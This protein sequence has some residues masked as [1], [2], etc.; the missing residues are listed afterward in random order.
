MLDSNTWTKNE[1]R[2]WVAIHFLL[3]QT[4]L[5]R[6]IMM[7]WEFKDKPLKSDAKH[8]RKESIA[9]VLLGGAYT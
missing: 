5:I 6:V 4:T 3:V 9:Q 8:Y 7:T 2:S 1:W